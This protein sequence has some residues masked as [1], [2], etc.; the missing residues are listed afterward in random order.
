MRH[1][2]WLSC[3]TL[4]SGLVFGQP[5]PDGKNEVQQPARLDAAKPATPPIPPVDYFRQLLAM[6]P[7]E[8]ERALANAPE[9]K[10]KRL[11]SKVQEYQKLPREERDSR[12]QL[13]QLHLYLPPLM[14]MAPERR[15]EKLNGIPSEDRKLIEDRL[16]QWDRL[17]SHLQKEVLEHETT[18]HYFLRLESGAPAQ[19][20]VVSQ[21][22]PPG[23]RQLEEKLEQWRA[24]KPEYRQKMY[25]QFHEFF[26]LPPRQKEK[27]LSALSDVER[28][29]MEKS[30][31][32]FARLPQAQRD[33]CIESFRQ[34]ANMSKA[35][36]DQFLKN[37]E[38]WQTMPS[39]ERETWRNLI[40]LFPKPLPPLPS[41]IPGFSQSP[42]P[43]GINRLPGAPTATNKVPL[44][45]GAQ[46]EKP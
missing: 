29:E 23:Y 19:Q 15:A 34:F 4:G 6:S 37:A 30:L 18:L 20:Q 22:L 40:N 31:Q 46:A 28:Q 36:R 10:R 25:Q 9:E 12:L 8:Q 27:T 42:P 41:G 44:L 38:R 2:F 33:M 11:E 1:F 14:R 7:A 32:T 39:S 24:L 35:D 43:K 17:P 26:E 16:E 5:V 21:N 45:P 3:C 13:V